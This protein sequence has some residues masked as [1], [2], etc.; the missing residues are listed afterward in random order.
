MVY[1]PSAAS[2]FWASPLLELSAAELPAYEEVFP[3]SLAPSEEEHPVRADTAI[4]AVTKA[5]IV[6]FLIIHSSNEIDFY[7]VLGR[8]ESWEACSAG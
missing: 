3:V 6:F 1:S 2:L 8:S 7:A 5:A 4:T